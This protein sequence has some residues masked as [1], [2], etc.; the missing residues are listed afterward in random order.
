MEH[1]RVKDARS[2]RIMFVSHCVLNQNAKVR[3][4]AEYA[5]AI[6]PIVEMLMDA[7]VGIIQM[8]CPEMTSFGAMRWG[9]VKDQYNS[10][11]F[12]RHCLNLATIVLEQAEEYH[13]AAYQIVGFLMMDG[14]PVCGLNSTP[15]PSD[16]TTMWGGMTWYI[17]EQTQV[18]DRG[19]F[20]EILL[21]EIGRREYLAGIPFVAYTEYEE[22]KTREE[23]LAEIRALL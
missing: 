15:Q 3:G 22:I 1:P 20:C 19:V 8:P 21:E 7:G 13:R 11:M 12:R 16:H 4:I 10:P 5:G 18:P 9:Q 2:G 17:P 6:R 14:S 23:A